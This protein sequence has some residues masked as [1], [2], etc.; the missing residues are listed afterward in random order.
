MAIAFRSQTSLSNTTRTNTTVT[1]PAG[2]VTG[3]DVIVAA[4]DIGNSSSVTISTPSGWTP[5]GSTS[6]A[7]GDP[8][9]VNVYC[10]VRVHDGSATYTFNHASASS[11][12]WCSAWSGADTTTPL[13]VAPTT[14]SEGTGSTPA[15]LNTVTIATTGA[16]EIA[17]RSSWDGN[18]ITAPAGWTERLDQPVLWVGTKTATS[19]PGAT[20]TTSIDPGNS[21]NNRWGT[22]HV[23][24]RPDAG[25]GAPA[26]PPILV[27][28]PRN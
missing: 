3:T 6:F 7:S 20:G 18:A 10:F 19:S 4:L 26:L 9:T 12:A 23:A 27:M 21:P 16:Q 1:A 24:L 28:R 11:E 13:D 22:I 5:A 25:G 17:I 8:Y 2:A 14:N 15:T